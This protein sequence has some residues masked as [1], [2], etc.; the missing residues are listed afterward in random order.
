MMR[1][2]VQQGFTLIELMIVVAIIGIL[3][4]TAIPQYQTYISKSQ[5]SRVMSEAGNLK[6]AVDSCILDG[7][8]D[9]TVHSNLAAGDA[10]DAEECNVAATS[11]TLIDTTVGVAQGDGANPA[12]GTGYPIVTVNANGTATIV[13]TFGNAAAADLKAT[14]S[15]LT[16][17]RDVNGTWTCET[18]AEAKYRPRGCDN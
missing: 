15:T 17:E 3:A 9:G 16:W 7:R 5:V 8:T 2:K 18:D 6:T 14:P 12:P 13:A 10:L 1:R 11:S 4:A